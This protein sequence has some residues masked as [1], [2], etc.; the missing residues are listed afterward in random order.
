MR[1]R[2]CIALPQGLRPRPTVQLEQRYLIDGMG[3]AV[4]LHGSNLKGVDVA[5]GVKNANSSLAATFQ[6]PTAADIGRRELSHAC[7]TTALR[8]GSSAMC[9]MTSAATLICRA[10]LLPLS[11]QLGRASLQ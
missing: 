10:G 5:D 8:C 3:F 2:R 11:K 9:A 1:L 7:V 6:L 4:K